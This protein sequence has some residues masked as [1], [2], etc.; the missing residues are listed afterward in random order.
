VSEVHEGRP[1]RSGRLTAHQK[2][3]YDRL[4]R[5]SRQGIRWVP[6][7]N[8]GSHSALWHLIN[9]GYAEARESIGPRGGVHYEY[10]SKQ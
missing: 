8:L 6:E 3:V 5:L 2:A 7:R 9:K 4:V 10:R 1:V